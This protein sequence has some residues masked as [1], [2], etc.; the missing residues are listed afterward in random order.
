MASEPVALTMTETRPSTDGLFI[1]YH[2]TFQSILGPTPSISLLQRDY[3][4]LATFHEACIYH[5][6]SKSVFVTSNQ[7]SLSNDQTSSSTSNKRVIITRIYDH[8]DPLRQATVDVTPPDLVMANGGVNYK[9]GLLFCAQG[10]KSNT[11]PS[12]LVFMADPKTPHQTKSLISSFHGRP[13][14][15]INDV[16]VHPR[17][18]SIWF[19]DPCYGYHQG[20]RPEPE[21]PSQVYRFDPEEGSIRAVADD[22]VRPNG[23]CF[24]PDL[25]LLYVTDT[26][27]VH[28]AETVPFD[29]SGKSSIYAFNIL[30]SKHGKLYVYSFFIGDLAL[31]FAIKDHSLPIDACLRLQN[32]AAP[33][34]SNATLKA[35]STVAAA[36]A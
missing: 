27:A 3:D 15:S 9:S 6:A 18:G 36:T 33:T 25:K 26:G 24:S 29:K 14:N 7:L 30:E 2:S 31:T 5:A 13:F 16:I 10:N 1:P 22:F 34:A 4:G 17:D 19:T 28:G 20:I 8:H 11:R 21:L 35:T 32:P 12:G 23:L